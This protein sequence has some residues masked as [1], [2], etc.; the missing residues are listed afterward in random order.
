MDHAVLPACDAFPGVPVGGVPPGPVPFGGAPVGGVPVGMVIPHAL[1]AA[2]T[3]ALSAG[4]PPAPAE[5]MA[6]GGVPLPFAGG[7]GALTP[8]FARHS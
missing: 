7:V 3:S 5:G 8:A 1:S 4:L 6:V 2:C